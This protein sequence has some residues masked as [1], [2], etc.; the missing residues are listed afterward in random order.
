MFMDALG[1]C[2]GDRADQSLVRTGAEEAQ[3]EATFDLADN[4]PDLQDVLEEHEIM[5][6][7]GELILRRVISRA[8][9]SRAF[10][11]GV[12]LTLQQLQ[13]V[14]ERLADIHGQQE[15]QLLLKPARHGELLDF[16]G[17]LGDARQAVVHAWHKWR[18][19][20][21][22]LDEAQARVLSQE[23]EEALLSAFLEELE[24]VNYNAGEEA[25]LAAERL[26]LMSSEQ[27]I[28]ALKQAYETLSGDQLFLKRMGQA[29]RA[30]EGAAE[31]AG[32]D[33][34]N[35]AERLGQLVL[36]IDDATR[37]MEHL[38]T[39]L[40]PDPDL[41]AQVDNRL[42]AL[43]DLARKHRVEVKDLPDVYEKLQGNLEDLALLQDGL[44]DLEK[45]EQQ[46][47]DAYEKQAKVLSKARH[48]MAPDLMKA[49]EQALKGLKM[50][51]TRFQVVLEALSSDQWNSN[52]MEKIS[53]QVAANPGSPLQPLEKVASGGEVSRLM[54]ALKSVF[55]AKM[56]PRTLVFD[57]IDTGI[58]GA[59]AD[60]A[61]EA[62]AALAQAHQ[63][64]AITH[65]PQVAA[66]GKTHLKIEKLTDGKTTRTIVTRLDAT[67][68]QEEL[69]RML[70]GRQVTEEARKAADSLLKGAA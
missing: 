42:A 43:R 20:R 6:E 64:V 60:A 68:R 62:L 36:E 7:D 30:L 13:S 15:Q 8:G 40:Q 12:R 67:K 38:A 69:A 33:V 16:F 58:G 53:F 39:T 54:L 19:L 11:N 57:E 17:Q 52:G 59:V 45:R 34:T 25:H 3:V 41:L 22:K 51:K 55:F 27:T 56:P 66:K 1:L 47:W 31:T 48:S 63:V 35:L 9:K 5:P 50:E 65:Q 61:G 32:Q 37:D 21:T 70:S 4:G 29:Q 2:L 23:R 46:A 26:R 44:E 14:G 10:A 18:R 24:E 49:V 28:E